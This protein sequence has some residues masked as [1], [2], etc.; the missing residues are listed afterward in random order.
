MPTRQVKPYRDIP[1]V[2]AEQ[3]EVPPGE[4][5]ASFAE[6][7]HGFLEVLARLEAQRCLSCRGCFGCGLCAVVC[8]PKAI[9]FSQSD[10]EIEIEA[11]SIIITPGTSK[12]APKLDE[13]YGYGICTD[14]LTGV[15]FERMLSKNGPYGG[16]VLRPSN[17]D[18]PERVA[19]IVCDAQG[20]TPSDLHGSRALSGA[21][22]ARLAL[23]AQERVPDLQAAVIGVSVS[24]LDAGAETLRLA[25]SN[26]RFLSGEVRR[27]SV[28]GGGMLTVD[29]SGEGS[30]ASE[31][32]HMV[33]LCT[34]FNLAPA[35]SKW[36]R[37]LGLEDRLFWQ[38]SDGEDSTTVG[39]VTFA[40][41]ARTGK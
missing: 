9:D 16:L 27:V 1:T 24:G 26:A 17:G 35:I 7:E 2:R 3:P 21:Y 36:A 34:G 41:L 23:V 25:R 4:R 39:D 28:N 33:V 6:V 18:I 22:A 37:K 19:F 8:K 38:D 20:L 29:L 32:F 10:K 15:E 30:V 31:Q 11:E 12:V 5:V 14:V 40:G 13:K